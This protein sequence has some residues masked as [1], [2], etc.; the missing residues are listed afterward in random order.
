MSKS[1]AALA[2][3]R[4]WL[5]HGRE[6]VR[7]DVLVGVAA[8]FTAD[9]L[10][11]YLGARLLDAGVVPEF[12]FSEYN[13]IHEVCFDP[14]AALGPVD[15]LVVLWRLEDLFGAALERLTEG[16]VAAFAEITDGVAELGRAIGTMA[17]AATYP[18]LVSVPPF[19]RPIGID[20]VDSVV[21][22]RLARAHAAA[23]ESFL[24]ALN[25][26]PVRWADLNAWQLSVG[27]ER[28]HD[29][30]KAL[31][32]KQPYTSEFWH[33]LG[34]NLG[35][36]VLREQR[37]TPKCIVLDCDNTLWGGV[38]G[39]DGVGGIEL[40]STF[41]GSAF[42]GFQKVLKSLKDRGVLLAIS[43]KNNPQVV[44]DVFAQHD[45][46]V[47]KAEDIAVW[48]VN[49]NPKSQS[50]QEI[51]AELNIGIDSL[52]MIDDSDYELAEIANAAPEAGR[53]QVPD[54]AGLLPDLI[55]SS[56]LFRNMK[57]S[58]EDLAR[59][60]M[61][62]QEAGRK[63]AAAA[64]TRDE[65]LA[66]LDLVVDYVEVGEEH[67]G[68]V[69]QLTNKTNQFNLTTIRRSEADIRGLIAD[70]EYLVRAMRV[71]DK[72]GDYGLVGV[73]ILHATGDAWEI[74]T[75]LMSCRVL[76]RGVETALLARLAA[77]A[78]A[79]GASALVGRYLPTPKNPMV[80]DLYTRHGFS[81]TSTG[82]FRA[83]LAEIT[84]APSHI[85]IG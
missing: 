27:V 65:F 29:V 48:R 51:A 68:R 15:H 37:P 2:D 73:A 19:P 6:S 12:S 70:Q 25:G 4:R 30:V 58:A 62:R 77:E 66:S 81:Q 42:L 17:S 82:V 76:S 18:V 8:S 67:V 55:A 64:M 34:S 84:P 44:A 35:D 10:Q 60:D 26:A 47:L 20:L 22:L 50:L 33:F 40:G 21:G 5:A 28:S 63:Q 71:G 56:G 59:T 85:K 41:P 83:D 74:D 54:E 69:A 49:W 11:A 57:V 53:L 72:F 78:G 24:S 79:G 36:I 39:E 80:A 45:D 52:V 32:Y 31:V 7:A 23:L 16:D 61:I 13:Q 3:Q 75:F 38:V 1:A 43:S 9:P 46:M 14:Q